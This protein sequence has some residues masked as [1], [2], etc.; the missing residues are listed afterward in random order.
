MLS[1]H[2]NNSAQSTPKQIAFELLLDEESK[3]RARIPLRILVHPDDVTDLI[4]ATV[5]A[6]YGIYEGHDVTFE[7]VRGNPLVAN[8][9]NLVDGM[10][11]NVRTVPGPMHTMLAAQQ[12]HFQHVTSAE[13][14]RRASLGEPFQMLPPHLHE[15]SRSPSRPSSRLARKRSTSPQVQRGRRSASHQKA[16]SASAASRG[17]SVNGQYQEDAFNNYSDS[18][19]GRS[20]V[21]GSRKARSEQY[22]SAEISSENILQ[23]GRRNKILFESSVCKLIHPRNPQ[24]LTLLTGTSTVRPSASAYHYIHVLYLTTETLSRPRR[25]P[26]TISFCSAAAWLS[27]SSDS[28]ATQL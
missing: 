14:Q 19:E 13:A 27:G 7:D 1:N 5:K 4:V 25:S 11:V 26:S 21:A 15:T 18:E 2:G 9:T 23:D 28:V 8:Y 17:S 3:T 10:T 24:K 22:A 12:G 20:S 16:G 6:F